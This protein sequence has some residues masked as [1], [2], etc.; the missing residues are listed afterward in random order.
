MLQS[1]WLSY[2][3]TVSHW[4]AAAVDRPQNAKFLSFYEVLEESLDVNR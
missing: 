1:G 2:S 4:S 3:Y